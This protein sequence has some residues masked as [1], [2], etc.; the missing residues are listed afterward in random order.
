[1]Y[2]ACS[3]LTD[4]RMAFDRFVVLAFDR[5]HSIV[6]IVIVIKV[7]I[8]IVTVIVNV[9]VIVNVNLQCRCQYHTCCYG[10]RIKESVS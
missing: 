10:Q 2:I 7:I 5:W 9:I 6:V 1:M 8:V 4:E 3:V